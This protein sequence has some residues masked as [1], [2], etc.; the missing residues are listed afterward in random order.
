MPSLIG[1]DLAAVTQPAGSLVDGASACVRLCVSVPIAIICTV[2]SSLSSAKRMFG[3][4]RE[5]R[6]MT[7]I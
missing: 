1:L 5:R 3:G 2:A 6:T 4:Q 7:G